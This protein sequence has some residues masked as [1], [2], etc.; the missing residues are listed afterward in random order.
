MALFTPLFVSSLQYKLQNLEAQV[1]QQQELQGALEVQLDGALHDRDGLE[2]E[3]RW[4]VEGAVAGHAGR[5]KGGA[6]AGAWLGCADGG[7]PQRGVS[8]PFSCAAVRLEGFPV[9][10]LTRRCVSLRCVLE[11]R[12]D[13]TNMAGGDGGRLDFACLTLEE[14]EEEGEEEGGDEAEGTG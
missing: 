8:W 1:A 14:A 13:A 10:M 12:R 9:S 4:M 5:A 2:A 3:L 11:Q 6:Q 7:G